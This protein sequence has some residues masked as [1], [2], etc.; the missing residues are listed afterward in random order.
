MKKSELEKAIDVVCDA[1]LYTSEEANMV[2]NC[3][4]L[5][6]VRWL[7]NDVNGIEGEISGLPRQLAEFIEANGE[8]WYADNGDEKE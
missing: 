6:H 7:Y 1:C 3:C 8:S 2:P 5:C 4:E